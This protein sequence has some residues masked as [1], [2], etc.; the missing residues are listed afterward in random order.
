MSTVAGMTQSL[1]DPNDARRHG[2]QSGCMDQLQLH[3]EQS[4]HIPWRTTT[5][6][7]QQLV[8]ATNAMA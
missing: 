5:P 6:Y 1:Q 2:T 3:D 8:P 7:F 4:P